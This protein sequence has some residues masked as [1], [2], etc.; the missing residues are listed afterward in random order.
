MPI[1]LRSLVSN[2]I[3]PSAFSAK[4]SQSN[5]PS[6]THRYFWSINSVCNRVRMAFI[7]HSTK[8]NVSSALA[9]AAPVSMLPSVSAVSKDLLSIMSQVCVLAPAKLACIK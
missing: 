4:M 7:F 9:Y 8:P 1:S 5:A 3:L 6:V 2:V